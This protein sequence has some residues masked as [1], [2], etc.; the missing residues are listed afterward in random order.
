MSK[1]AFLFP[2]QGSQKP[3]MLLDT[4][5]HYPQIQA[6]FEQASE[7]LSDD[8]W[9]MLQNADVATMSLTANTQPL[10]LT[11]GVALWRIWQDNNG[12][13]PEIMAGHSLGEY[14]ALACS[15]AMQFEDARAPYVSVVKRCS[16]LFL[17]EPVLWPLSLVLKTRP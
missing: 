2:G 17:R 3:G 15:G 11:S 5:Q 14:T 4:A 7:A 6:T 16:V 1:L 9:D 13:Q 12:Q 8:L 10:L